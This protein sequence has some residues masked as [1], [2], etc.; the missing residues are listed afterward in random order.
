[1]SLKIVILASILLKFNC[2]STSVFKANKENKKDTILIVSMN[3]YDVNLL[4]NVGTKVESF[5]K[6]PVKYITKNLP[7]FAYI[8]SINRYNA[9]KLIQY[10]SEINTDNYKFIVGITSKDICTKKDE[11][12]NWGIF[13][14]GTLNNTGCVI[15]TFRMRNNVSPSKLLIRTQKVVLHEIGH[16]YGLPH[17]TTSYPC[18]MKDAR[19]TIKEVDEEPLELCK[20]CKNKIPL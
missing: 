20:V 1:M 16:N 14:L 13:G 9:N 19:G 10:L 17:C 2:F 6:T 11:Y 7:K 18:F 15:S 8:P 4:A 12:L 5:Y 3:L